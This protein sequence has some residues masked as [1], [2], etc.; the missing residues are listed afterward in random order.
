MMNLN[1][2]NLP[3]IVC[4]FFMGY[5]ISSCNEMEDIHAPYIKD[6]ETLYISKPQDMTVRSGNGRVEV[7]WRLT[8]IH[9]VD[10]AIISYD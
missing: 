9:N 5:F 10:E 4:L 8:S 6:G 7:S 2:R 1:M 3:G